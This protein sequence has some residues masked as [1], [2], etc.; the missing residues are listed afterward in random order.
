LQDYSLGNISQV[1]KLSDKLTKK[2]KI[3]VT[4][5]TNKSGDIPTNLIK[6]KKGVLMNAMKKYIITN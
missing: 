3:Q 1:D 2:E 5:N 6:I 4:G